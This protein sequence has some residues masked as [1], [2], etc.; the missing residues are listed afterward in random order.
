MDVYYKLRPWTD[1]ESCECDSVESLFLIVG[2]LADNPMHCGACR[3]EV[4]PE[5]LGLT[6]EETEVV[7][8]WNSTADALYRLWLDSG[9]YEHY[10]RAR[11]LDPHG[12]VSQRGLELA[13]TLSSRVPTRVWLFRDTDDGEPTACPVCG[14]PLDADVTWGAGCCAP[15]RVQV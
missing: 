1:I 6:V 14:S 10:A 8:D 7:A 9:E 12:Q 15:C 3:R 13:A 5:R 11:L 2:A 4:D